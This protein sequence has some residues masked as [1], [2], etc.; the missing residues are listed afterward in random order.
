MAFEAALKMDVSGFTSGISKATSGISSLASTVKALAIVEYGGRALSSMADAVASGFKGMYSAMEAGGAL[1]DLR[2]QTG[3][4]VDKLMVLR[5]AFQQA[6]MGADEVQPVINKMQKA[7]ETAATSGGPAAAAF[8]QMGLSAQK[9]SGMRADEQLSAIGNAINGIQNPTQKAAAAMEIFGKSGGR[10]LALFASGGLND[11]AVAVGNQARLMKDNAGVFDKV[12]DILGTAAT[13]LQGLYVGIASVVAPMIMDAAEAFNKIDLSGL[14]QQIGV[15]IAIVLE[16]FSTGTLGKL[17]LE[18]MRYAF[19]W[20]INFLSSAFAGIFS[21][22]LQTVVDTF[23]VLTTADFW[24]GMLTAVVGAAQEF[25]AILA[26]G[27]AGVINE[28]ATLPGIGDKAAKA[29]GNVRGYAQEVRGR[30][31]ENTISGLE[32]L[33]PLIANMG[34]DIEAAVRNAAKAAPQMEQSTVINDLLNKLK[35]GVSN[36][37]AAVRSENALK[38]LPM[39]APL[40]MQNK[41]GAFDFVSSLTK[42]GGNMFGATN[43]DNVGMDIARQQLEQQ[44]T[45]N[46]KLDAA[47]ASLKLIAGRTGSSGVVYG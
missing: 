35:Q 27:V 32:A 13:K 38:E 21:G 11:A 41:P 42:I 1:V 40:Q 43:T 37:G 45:Q 18:S 36:T 6:G 10:A 26:D 22:L 4:A 12:T 2:E 30:G 5:T 8:Q 9:L 23:S 3:L 20:A 24:A 14:G 19:T 46:T 47:I 16:A 28:F 7:I 44:R 29:A 31:L 17:T 33:Q 34:M 15:V 39:G 25:I